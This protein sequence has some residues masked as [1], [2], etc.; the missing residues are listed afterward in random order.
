MPPEAGSRG[1]A[2]PPPG[3]EEQWVERRAVSDYFC[4][5][6]SQPLTT[7]GFALELALR[8]PADAQQDRGDLERAFQI[9]RELSAR[10]QEV[11]EQVERSAPGGPASG[12]R[13]RKV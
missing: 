12:L 5:E 10:M 6:L 7:L 4:H 13:A 11:R 1:P 3:S 2:L 9:V 8:R